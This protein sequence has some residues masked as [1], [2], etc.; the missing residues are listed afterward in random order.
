MLTADSSGVD[1]FIFIQNN[2]KK[3]SHI[4]E[5]VCVVG[6]VFKNI[7]FRSLGLL[8]LKMKLCV[9]MGLS[10]CVCTIPRCVHKTVQN[11]F[12]MSESTETGCLS[13]FV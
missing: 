1:N 12:E 13:V 6:A 10:I 11:T 8:K 5:L 7:F 2:L 4:F 9:G 3:N